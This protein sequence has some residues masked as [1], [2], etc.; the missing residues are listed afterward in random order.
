M[1]LVIVINVSHFY[2]VHLG[3]VTDEQK[4]SGESWRLQVTAS[5]YDYLP[6]TGRIAP[7]SPPHPP[8]DQ[9]E[10]KDLKLSLNSYSRGTNW[11]KINISSPQKA[12]ITLATLVFPKTTILI[13]GI[14]QNFTIDPE[15]GRPILNIDAGNSEIYFKIT[16]TTIRTFSNILSIMSLFL[17]ILLILNDR[18]KHRYIR[19]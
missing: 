7:Q 5:I 1:F 19:N 9:V 13:N 11:L 14:A 12:K 16:N 6:K 15:L 18:L 17:I 3:P 8:I 2:P 4:I 10:P